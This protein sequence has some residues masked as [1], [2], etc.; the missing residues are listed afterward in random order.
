M[1][2]NAAALRGITKHYKNF[3]LGPVDLTVPAGSIVGLFAW[4]LMVVVMIG[5]VAWLI[6]ATWLIA[7]LLVVAAVAWAVVSGLVAAMALVVL[8]FTTVIG[9]LVTRRLVVFDRWLGLAYAR[10]FRLLL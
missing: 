2:A 10:S 7:A 6:A 5:L 3:T 1:A 4:C 9:S 8:C